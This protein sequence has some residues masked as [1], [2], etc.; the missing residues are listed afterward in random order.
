MWKYEKY[1]HNINL[2]KVY[3]IFIKKIKVIKY[4]IKKSLSLKYM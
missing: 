4:G 1:N 2:T 3:K